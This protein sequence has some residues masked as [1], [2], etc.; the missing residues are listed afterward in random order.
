MDR[1]AFVS[2]RSGRT[3]GPRVRVTPA[4]VLELVYAAFYLNRN[5]SGAEDDDA[6]PWARSLWRDRP[7]VAGAA[8]ELARR[9]VPSPAPALFPLAMTSGHAL[10]DDPGRFLAAVP[11]LADAAAARVREA[12]REAG[13]PDDAEAAARVG[14][15]DEAL[16]RWL[17]SPD[18]PDWPQAVQAGLGALWDEIG[19]DWHETGRPLAEAA[20][21]RVRAALADH[22]DVLRALPEHHFAQFEKLAASLRDAAD[23]GRLWIVPLALAAAGGFHT[24]I[25]DTTAL[26][27]GLQSESVHARAEQ[28]VAAAAATAK[29]LADPTRLMLL[30]LVARY[31]N[32]SLTVG[33]L[34][35]QLGV[36]Q[37]TVSGHLKQLRDAGLVRSERRGNRSYPRVDRPSLDAALDRIGRVLDAERSS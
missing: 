29:A 31:P 2:F 4:P 10:D 6:L 12:G 13:A 15:V 32:L 11:S 26:G 8:A 20:A 34:A 19:P 27:F 23:R 1:D 28:R 21:E 36:S 3:E 9:D 14:D 37:P 5:R 16:A 30:H 24:V 17:L 25:D 18:D 35:R 7:E 33:D 22:A